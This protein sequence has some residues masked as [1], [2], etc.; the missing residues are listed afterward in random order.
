MVA[1][2]NVSD[3]S[4]K[5]RPTRILSDYLDEDISKAI[6]L[7]DCL[8]KFGKHWTGDITG[9]LGTSE[10]PNE[11]LPRTVDKI[12]DFISHDWAT[13]GWKKFI[14]LCL[15]YN[16]IP[17]AVVATIF[18]GTFGILEIF[19]PELRR[20]AEAQLT[21]AGRQVTMND[22]GYFGLCS[23]MLSFI[24]VLFFWQRIRNVFCLRP[25]MV[26]MDKLCIHQTDL[27]LKA[28]GILGLAGFLRISSNL[29]VLW[30]PRYFTRLWCVYEIAS[31]LS[32]QKPLDDIDVY[33]VA[34]GLFVAYVWIGMA[35]LSIVFVWTARLA[36]TEYNIFLGSCVF[37]VYLAPT[38]YIRRLAVDL[39]RMPKQVST[40]DFNNAECFCCSVDH[41][42]P[43]PN[44][45]RRRSSR[46]SLRGS[47]WGGSEEEEEVPIIE[48]PC[49]RDMISE[50]LEIWFGQDANEGQ[51]VEDLFSSY[52]RKQFGKTVCR[53]VGGSRVAYVVAVIA[54]LPGWMF[55]TDR[56]HLL[57][58]LNGMAAWRLLSHYLASTFGAFPL[59]VRFTLYVAEFLDSRTGIPENRFLDFLI[60]ICAD[61]VACMVALAAYFAMIITLGMEELWPQVVVLSCVALLTLLSYYRDLDAWYHLLRRFSGASDMPARQN[62]LPMGQNTQPVRQNTQETTAAKERP[63]LFDQ[64]LPQNQT[65]NMQLR[66]HAAH[67]DIFVEECSPPGTVVIDISATQARP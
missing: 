62:S 27:D 35:L 39:E 17:A 61:L 50:K 48:I 2:T 16:S 63:Q 10:N 40:F 43:D 58:Q 18:S 28:K 21:V 4:V 24:V 5:E 67:D 3:R 65:S 19:F 57:W 7:E 31:W 54:T 6:R 51:T 60:T 38:H 59:L 1:H 44:P 9:G 12:D 49:D 23:G 64:V 41:K 30:S 14:T 22:A 52:V 26:F 55:I 11:T 13:K 66:T 34:Q 42:I 37:L 46:V 33:P 53:R 45:T 32:M 20:M 47:W 25:R 15:V 56:F 29:V 36:D 8:E